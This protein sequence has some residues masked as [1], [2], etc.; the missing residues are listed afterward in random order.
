MVELLVEPGER[1][2]VGDGNCLFA[3]V[4]DQLE[5]LRAA[6]TPLRVR[7]YLSRRGKDGRR[8]RRRARQLSVRLL[9]LLTTDWLRRNRDTPLAANLTVRQ[10]YEADA[11]PLPWEEYLA[12]QCRHAPTPLPEEA[13]GDEYGILAIANL[14][15]VCVVVYQRDAEGRLSSQVHPPLLPPRSAPALHL[16]YDGE[17][18]HYS[19]ADLS[20]SRGGPG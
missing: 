5:Q 16:L 19:S 6:E 9:R 1:P 4:L 18:R 11:P 15:R 8:R 12:S 10:L 13:W 2:I 17:A 14:L 20:P 3:S 7:L